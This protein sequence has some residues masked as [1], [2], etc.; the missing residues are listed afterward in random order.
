MR[1]LVWLIFRARC[2]NGSGGLFYVAGALGAVLDKQLYRLPCAPFAIAVAQTAP[3]G[4]H[5]IN[6]PGNPQTG[7]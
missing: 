4:D 6:I 2:H 1:C 3:E 7:A 5:G